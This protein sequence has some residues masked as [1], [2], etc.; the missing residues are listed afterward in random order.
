MVDT[1]PAASG[2][3]FHYCPEKWIRRR[4]GREEGKDREGRGRE[5]R[6]QKGCVSS[7][8]SK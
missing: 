1:C 4:E 3:C 2:F 6:K 7:K 5:G 8:N